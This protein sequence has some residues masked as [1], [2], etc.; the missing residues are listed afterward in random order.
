MHFYGRDDVPLGAY[1]GPWARDPD[2]G[3]GTA[4]KYISD[5]VAHYPSPI[6]NSSQ[7]PDTVAVYAQD[8]SGIVLTGV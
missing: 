8:T 5:L 4:D 7:V 1:K 3:T 2:A 6:K